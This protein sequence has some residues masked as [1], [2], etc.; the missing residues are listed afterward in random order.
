M[1]C[2]LKDISRRQTQSTYIG[3]SLA[4]Q[5]EIATD[6]ITTVQKYPVLTPDY[7]VQTTRTS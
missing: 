2:E 6:S 1:R 7:S 3:T 4:V 5:Y